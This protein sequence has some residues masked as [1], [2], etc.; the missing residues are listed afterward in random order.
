MLRRHRSRLGGT[1]A[2]RPPR[3]RL[4]NLISGLSRPIAQPASPLEI[5][6]SRR[7]TSLRFRAS[8][9]KWC[10]THHRSRLWAYWARS[11]LAVFYAAASSSKVLVQCRHL[12]QWIGTVAALTRDRDRL[13]GCIR[14]PSA[15]AMRRALQHSYQAKSVGT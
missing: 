5:F 6:L 15:T 8:A 3:R 13:C 4:P 1:S 2:G 12:D 9:A 7:T 14:P 11:A 10:S